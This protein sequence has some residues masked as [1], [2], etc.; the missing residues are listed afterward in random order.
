MI[1]EDPANEAPM[2]GLKKQTPGATHTTSALHLIAV[3]E[4]APSAGSRMLQAQRWHSAS[5]P[6]TSKRV[7][8]YARR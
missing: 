5:E 1:A 3:S 8:R 6:S 4:A 2:F 7:L